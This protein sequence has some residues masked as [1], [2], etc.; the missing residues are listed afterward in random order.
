M[1]L[2]TS[3][4]FQKLAYKIRHKYPNIGIFFTY[5]AANFVNFQCLFFNSKVQSTF[6]DFFLEK[7]NN[8]FLMKFL[9]I[10]IHN[11]CMTKIWDWQLI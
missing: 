3:A 8:E 9:A 11:A 4:F 10:S 7:I 1:L 5:Y 2:V 6:R